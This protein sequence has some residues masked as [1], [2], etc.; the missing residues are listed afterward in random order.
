MRPTYANLS[1]PPINQPKYVS[2]DPYYMKIQ[3]R[4]NMSKNTELA[5]KG[6]TMFIKCLLSCK[7]YSKNF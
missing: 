3:L 7:D 2:Y 4:V 1:N 5:I 6:K